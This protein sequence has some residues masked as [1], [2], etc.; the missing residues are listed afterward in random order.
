MGLGLGG[1]P[2]KGGAWVDSHWWKLEGRMAS[3]PVEL[4]GF[5][6][7]LE[8]GLAGVACGSGVWGLVL[9][10]ALGLEGAGLMKREEERGLVWAV[11]LA[12][13]S[14]GLMSGV[15]GGEGSGLSGKRGS[16]GEEWRESGSKGELL[17]L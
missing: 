7:G 11:A 1:G 13:G 10:V 16:S 15:G 4:D 5:L 12:L 9:A 3:V 17:K 6:G 14:G 8:V 2:V